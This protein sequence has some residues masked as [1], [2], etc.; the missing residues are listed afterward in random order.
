MNT[1]ESYSKNIRARSNTNLCVRKHACKSLFLF[2]FVVFSTSLLRNVDNVKKSLELIVLLFCI[3]DVKGWN[4]ETSFLVSFF[5]KEKCLDIKSRYHILFVIQVNSMCIVNK[6]K[7]NH[8]QEKSEGLSHSQENRIIT[9][10]RKRKK[11]ER[12]RLQTFLGK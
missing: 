1:L 11:R 10:K 3:S 6:K 12:V 7:N 8:S 2:F 5:F 9:V 4:K